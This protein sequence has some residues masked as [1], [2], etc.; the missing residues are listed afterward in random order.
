MRTYAE[1]PYARP[2]R[3]SERS[4][5]SPRLAARALIAGL[6]ALFCMAF[7]ASAASAAAPAVTIDPAS[8]VGVTSA[9][10]EGTVDPNGAE[11]TYRFE[12]LSDEAFN[13]EIDEVQGALIYAPTYTYTF[14][15]QTTTTLNE[16]STAVEIQN[17]LNALSTIGG[18]GGSVAV[19]KYFN[20]VTVT[21]GG[22]LAAT[23]VETLVYEGNGFGITFTEREGHA[24]GFG[25]A[26]S[27]GEGT[28][29]G[30]DPLTAVPPATLE[31]LQPDT[32][33]HLRLV[34]TNADG[35]T[36][37][38]APNFTTDAA[39]APTVT[40]DPVTEVGYTRAV[41]PGK[42]DPEGGNENPSGGPLPIEW[43]FEF[44]SDPASGWMQGG[45]G[46]ISGDEAASTDP[47]PVHADTGPIE[48]ETE[49]QF[50]LVATYAGGSSVTSSEGSFKTKGPIT[51]PAAAAI[52]PVTAIT[53]T[54]AHFSGHVTAGN[55]DPGFNASC[56]FLYLTDSEFQ[57]RD[58]QQ[59]LIVSATGG[60][61]TLSFTGPNFSS[62]TTDPIAYDADAAAVQAALEALGNIGSGDVA[63]SGG[64]GGTSPYTIDFTG[65]LAETGLAPLSADGSALTGTGSEAV[66][67]TT[68]EGHSGFEGALA[69]PC[70][71]NGVTGEP[72]TGTAST[73][74]SADPI[75]LKP[76]NLYHVRLRA[77][78]RAGATVADTTF[79]T[80]VIEPLVRTGSVHVASTTATLAGQ[81]NPSGAETTYY[82]EYGP[83]FGQKT[84]EKTIVV[85]NDPVLASETLTGLSPSTTYQ[86]RLVATNSAGT[87]TGAT[88]SFTTDAVVADPCPNA[89]FRTGFAANLPD[90]RAYELVNPP[91]REWG[92]VF[93]MVSAGDDGDYTGFTT[94][95]GG[96]EA[97]GA[98]TGI[99]MLAHRTPT[100]WETVDSNAALPTGST[101]LVITMP[102]AYSADH[103]RALLYSQ[104]PLDQ[105]NDAFDGGPDLY[106][107]DVG[108][109][110][111]R[112]LSYGPN[113]S[114]VLAGGF[115]VIGASSDLSRVV[116]TAGTELL[117]GVSLANALYLRDGGDLQVVSVLP[118]GT[119]TA[120]GPVGDWGPVARLPHGGTRAV[121]D[122]ARRVY[123][124]ANFAGFGAELYLRDMTMEPAQTITVSASE[125]TGD[126]GAVGRGAF[127]G[128]SHDGSVAYFE[129][130]EQL[131]DAATPA[132]G[133]YRFDLDAPVGQ[134]LE[135][136]TPEIQGNPEGGLGL[137]SAIVSDDASHVYFT[138]YEVLTPD[139]AS[140]SVLKGY[141]SDGQTTKLVANFGKRPSNP[142][143]GDPARAA[144]ASRDGRFAIFTSK[145]VVD[146]A[147]TSVDGAP[148]NGHSAIYEYDDNSGDVACA[149]CRPDGSPSQGDA[150]LEGVPPGPLSPGLNAP[151]NIA[152][153]GTVFFTSNDQI[154]A[155][156]QTA[157]TDVYQYRAGKVAL[158]TSGQGN[159]ASY[160]GDNSD[161][162]ETVF[163]TSATP[164]VPQDKDAGEID[165]YAIRVNGGFPQPPPA[166]A[167]CEGEACRGAVS[168]PPPAA[169]PGTPGFFGAG[170]S[171]S[172]RNQGK[173][174][175]KKC[176]KKHRKRCHHKRH[177]HK[178]HHKNQNRDAG[179]NGRTGR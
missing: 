113:A 62:D 118:D 83:G 169:A 87:T 23:D 179:R 112:L 47:I 43:H 162:G 90:C 148:T 168:A 46:T 119:T 130:A 132:G 8:E 67:N 167:S 117:P 14:G 73:P 107:L 92:E 40:V 86:Y 41:L 96:D 65:T 94:L 93:R 52:E 19:S 27:A 145:D 33:Y 155:A 176:S 15:G 105:E 147:P 68:R 91:G 4:V 172:G 50:R 38:V 74:V 71:V 143:D 55:D 88:K 122:D 174:H 89:E 45:G 149:S 18:V 72:V 84:S 37:A 81:V 53:G 144:R 48:P 44:T 121:S 36:A 124:G 5:A 111:T 173:K 127:I 165:A 78:N 106:S 140:G 151:R 150:F 22:S 142:A 57:P 104:Y 80:P 135:Q 29:P 156:D 163:V 70:S 166:A 137:R 32:T 164:F 98:Q 125:R 75:D 177:H 146:G 141:V 109:G 16:G 25:G 76:G 42:I 2:L 99:H 175:H 129:S 26:A 97:L 34:A 28:L 123:F 59:R 102:L 160:I 136:I 39:T 170:N 7:G 153:D 1:A 24:P 101:N 56:E 21:F 77:S 20:S 108:S 157:F 3:G 9:K 95:I 158:L 154:V 61:Y 134:R 82:F 63:V 35:S 69:A 54:S 161:D 12:Y 6:A 58:A 178:K 138:S 60:T 120:T 64:P 103:S 31:N 110:T 49:Y 116:F 126:G 11:T 79:S 131:T 85:G 152:D 17:A 139:A 133:I 66:V 30:G 51:P 115:R 128:A 13:A 114:H 100:G 159:R 171:K 10:A